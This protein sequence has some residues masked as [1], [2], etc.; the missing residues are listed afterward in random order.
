M[1]NDARSGRTL[2]PEERE[3]IHELE[4]TIETLKE[5][6]ARTEHQWSAKYET[7]LEA[8]RLAVYKRFVRTAETADESQRLLFD[9]EPGEEKPKEPETVAVSGHTRKKAG[10][11]PLD[12]KLPREEI[13]HDIPEEEKVCACG[14]ELTKIGEEVSERL[15]VIPEQIYVERHVRPKYACRNCE[16]SGDEEKAAVR[17]VPA[18]PSIIP[19]SI[20][21]PGLLAFIFVNKYVDHLPFYRQEKLFE[22]IGVVIS[23]QD[24]SHWQ[25]TVYNALKPLYELMKGQLRAGPVL[26]MDETTVQVMDEPG[27]SDTRK[28]YMWLSLGGPPGKP[29]AWYAYRETRSSKHINEFLDGFSGYLQTDG[30]EGYDTAVKAFPGIVHVGCF[31]HARRKFFEASAVT[32]KQG[33]AEEGLSRIGKLYRIE[34]DLRSRNLDP[35]TFCTL[36]KEQAEPILSSFRGWLEKS[37]SQVPPE[38]LIGKAVSY[39]LGE[40]DKL[41]RYLDSPYLTPDNNACENAI[42]PFVLG[43][44]NW[45]FSGSPHGAISSCGLYSLIETAKLNGK[46]PYWYLA[47]VFEQVPLISRQDEWE[48]FLPWNVKPP[49]KPPSP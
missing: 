29:V 49:L 26:R 32:K 8:Y 17:V 11:K 13:V 37:A 36:R 47:Y 15:R 9:E 14:C 20:V 7:L 12:E 5:N 21:T 4:K 1:S 45:L 33:K 3:Y 16:G 34:Q 22:R 46:N 2:P 6:L 31:A 38:T 39:T 19:K 35:E 24:M 23:R 43:R 18:V 25:G 42:R 44:K 48:T 40:W 27:R 30:Y 41:V 10:R 28:S